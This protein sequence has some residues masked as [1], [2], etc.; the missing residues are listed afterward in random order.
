MYIIGGG[1]QVTFF[2]KQLKE[3]ESQ[4][5]MTSLLYRVTTTQHKSDHKRQKLW[6]V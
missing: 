1:K 2:F 5:I 6:A 4:K 3:G